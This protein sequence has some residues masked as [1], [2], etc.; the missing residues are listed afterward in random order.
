MR[1][2]DPMQQQIVKR[3]T[4]VVFFKN[5]EIIHDNKEFDTLFKPLR[6]TTFSG[7]D[8]HSSPSKI[9]NQEEYVK[10]SEFMRLMSV[11]IMRQVMQHTYDYLISSPSFNLSQS[12]LKLQRSILIHGVKDKSTAKKVSDQSCCGQI[13]TNLQR[14]QQRKDDLIYYNSAIDGQP[15]FPRPLYQE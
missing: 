5:K 2:L 8:Q 6:A 9:Y 1:D 4:L 11:S 3:Q 10:R 15:I 12:L 13:V 7:F 14:I